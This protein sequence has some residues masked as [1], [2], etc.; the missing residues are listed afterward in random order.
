MAVILDQISCSMGST[1]SDDIRASGGRWDGRCPDPCLSVFRIAYEA[2][3][4]AGLS[5]DL[6]PEL[7]SEN[8][9]LHSFRPNG[10]KIP[11]KSAG[12]C[13]AG[14]EYA[15]LLQEIVEGRGH[16]SHVVRRKS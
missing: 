13:G 3:L 5:G 14:S 7:R 16:I 10:R 15:S 1:P 2:A 8:G 11:L 4:A 6:M 9:V 12:D